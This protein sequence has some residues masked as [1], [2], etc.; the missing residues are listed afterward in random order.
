M[1]NK[2]KNKFWE[3]VLTGALLT[4]FAGLIIVGMSTG[5]SMIGRSVIE[6]KIESQGIESQVDA[7]E[8]TLDLNRIEKK[9]TLIQQIIDAYFLYEEDLEE[10]EDG[11]YAGLMYGLGDPYAAYYNKEDF[12][13]LMEDTEGIYCGIGTMVSQNVMTGIITSVR[14]FEGTPAFEAGMLPGDIIYKV[15]GEEVT[16]I[17]LDLV[18]SRYIKGEEGTEVTITVMRDGEYLD[19]TME[20]RMVETPTVEHQMLEDNVGYI[21]VTQFDLM[22]CSQFVSAVEDL[23]SQGMEKLVIDLRDNPG[24]VLD[25]AVD[26][27]AY[28]LPED[29]MDG[30]LVYTEDKNGEGDQFYCEDGEI[31]NTSDHGTP[32]SDYPKK[33][34]HQLDLP[35]AVLVN[36]DS[37]SAS[38]LFT[39]ALKD[40]DWATVVGTQTFGKGIVQN[41]IPLGDG[42]AVKLTVS[43][44][45]TPSGFSLHEVGITPDVEVE[46]D[47]ELQDQVVVPLEE[48]NQLKRA[49]E[50]LEGQE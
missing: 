49:I 21:L 19:L 31:R 11:I 17:S 12:D 14:V 25:A 18:V 39:G 6:N 47:E 34:G 41:L 9:M 40:Y 15:D 28:I 33:D 38:E 44:Y 4:A 46:L 13:L 16:G 10:V 27:L 42:S 48:D 7:G 5:I 29:Q 22:T 2:T 36:G 8:E 45:Y 20:R 50:E 3:G 26:M 32:N 30:L 1:E 24:G 35:I 43:K 37:A 23:E